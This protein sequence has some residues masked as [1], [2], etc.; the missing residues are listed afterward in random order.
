MRTIIKVLISMTSLVCLIAAYWIIARYSNLISDSIL[1]KGK[2]GNVRPITILSKGLISLSIL[3]ISLRYF[4]TVFQ[5]LKPLKTIKI[6]FF[7]SLF[8]ILVA[9]MFWADTWTEAPSAVLDARECG[10]GVWKLGHPLTFIIID[11]TI[12]LRHKY[13][14]LQEYWSDWWAYPSVLILFVIQF[15]IYMQGLR[16]MINY[17]RL[18]EVYNK[19]RGR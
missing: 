3:L 14:G 4:N 17:K 19:N 18:K 13:D 6:G 1:D 9:T 7:T 2:W 16:M 5:I 8:F 15:S 10:D 11:L 12:Y